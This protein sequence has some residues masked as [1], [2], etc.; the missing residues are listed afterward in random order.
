[1]TVIALSLP[2]LLGFLVLAV[3]LRNEHDTGLVERL[4]FSYPLG[5]GLL[6]VQMFVLGLLRV[7]L[8]LVNTSLPIFVEIVL[9]SAWIVIQKITVVPKLSFGLRDV[10]LSPEVSRGKKIAVVLLILWAGVKLFSVFVE[11]GLRPIYAWDAWANWSVG[12]KLF[13]ATKSL[14]LDSPPQDFFARGAVLRI[15]AY[16]LHN[17]M[18]QT[19]IS[20]WNGGFDEVLVKFWNPVYLL[21]LAGCF[22]LTARRELNNLTALVLLVV[23]LSSP[24]LSYHAIEAYS[25]LALSVYLFLATISFLYAMRGREAF[26]ILTGAFSAQALFTKDEA[27]FFVVPLCISA[28]FYIWRDSTDAMRKQYA[29]MKLA[30][31]LILAAPWYI[32]KFS[33]AL[34]LGADVIKLEFTF[35]PEIILSAIQQL[36]S[37]GSFNVIIVFF[38]LLLLL[39]GKPSQEFLHVFLAAASYAVFFAAVY[40]CTTFYY[41]NF[42]V[43]TVFFRNI[44]TYYPVIGLLTILLL[45][46]IFLSIK[47]TETRTAGSA[48]KKKKKRK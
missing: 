4:C 20:L 41:F 24:L 19:W 7:Q 27:L 2:A 40:I 26:W 38:P 10:F 42:S 37:L 18:M 12:A 15:T 44:L 1:M 14:L 32:F 33:H 43:G 3:L 13:Y 39:S 22:Y 6:T 17:P 47:P 25:D 30:V 34:G 9:L 45:K 48:H 16:P 21:C 36:Y 5:T 31:P 8:T 29:M 23:F 35:H 28:F 11:T 46:S